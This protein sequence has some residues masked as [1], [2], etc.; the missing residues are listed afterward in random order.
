MNS[1]IKDSVQSCQTCQRSKI[2]RHTKSPIGIFSL[3]YARFAHIN[4]DF[5]GPLPPSDGYT[6]CMTII[7]RF[8]RW[9][10]VIPTTDITAET[11]CKAL[12]HNW[13]P[14]FGCPVTITTDQGRNFDSHLFTHLNDIP[15]STYVCSKFDF[16]LD[17]ILSWQI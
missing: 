9:P 17:I 1:F 7:D 11:T 12:I 6:Y 13:I 5:I 14:R 15:D 16:L 8:T 10:E 4:I 3:P 2:Q